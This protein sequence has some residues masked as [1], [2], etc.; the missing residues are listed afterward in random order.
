[1]K[2]DAAERQTK[3][4]QFQTLMGSII[5]QEYM[6]GFRDYRLGYSRRSKVE[7]YLKGYADARHPDAIPPVP[8]D[9]GTHRQ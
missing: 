1:L 7:G 5:S 9:A 8:E 2:I 3:K 4:A 6:R